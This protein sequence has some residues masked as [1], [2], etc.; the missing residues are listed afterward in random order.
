LNTSSVVLVDDARLFLCT[1]PTP[2]NTDHWP[3]FH[4]IVRKLFSLSDSHRMMV[5]N[6]VIAFYPATISTGMSAYASEHAID[7]LVVLRRLEALEEE[8]Q[9]LHAALAERLAVIEEMSQALESFRS[10]PQ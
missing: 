2:H 4:E 1:P 5:I 10:R 8:R 6:D 7:W 3:E 9:V